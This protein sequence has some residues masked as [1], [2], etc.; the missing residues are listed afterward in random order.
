LGE[1]GP[2]PGGGNQIIRVDVL[3]QMGSF[4]TDLGP[5]GHDLGGGEDTEYVL[6]CLRAGE[7]LWYEPSIV[8]YHYVDT[9]RL[10]LRYLVRKAFARSAAHAKLHAP[11]GRRRGI[12]LYLYRKLASHLLMAVTAWRQRRRRFYLVRTAAVLGEI[13][14]HRMT[15]S[16]SSA[17]TSRP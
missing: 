5:Q 11:V 2:I 16:R 9:A 17:H 3:R 12:P 1:E 7:R 8:Q 13:S 15:P 10:A 4:V 14:A 6:R